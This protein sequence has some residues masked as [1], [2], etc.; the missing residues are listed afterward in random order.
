MFDV[1]LHRQTGVYVRSARSQR[2]SSVT[3][4]QNKQTSRRRARLEIDPSPQ[5]Q[6]SLGVLNHRFDR[7]I[8][9]VV[10]EVFRCLAIGLI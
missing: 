10:S 5:A 9:L 8:F 3:T 1:Y 7:T 4:E 2:R 6:V